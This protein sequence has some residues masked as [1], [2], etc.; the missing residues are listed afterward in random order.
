MKMTHK[1]D[2]WKKYYEEKCHACKK[3]NLSIIHYSNKRNCMQ[4]SSLNNI[5]SIKKSNS[6]ISVIIIYYYALCKGSK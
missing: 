4:S 5:T 3:G 6:R 2:L 1:S